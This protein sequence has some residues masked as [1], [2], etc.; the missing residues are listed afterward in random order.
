[1][2]LLLVKMVFA[3]NIDRSY[4]NDGVDFMSYIRKQNM[5]SN[6]GRYGA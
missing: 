4:E 3:E 6:A 2:D 1:M 5:N